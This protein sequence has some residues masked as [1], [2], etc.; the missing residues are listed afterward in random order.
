MFS[1]GKSV[2]S[3]SFPSILLLE[4]KRLFS[5]SILAQTEIEKN[6][7]RLFLLMHPDLMQDYS[8]TIIHKNDNSMKVCILVN[9]LI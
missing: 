5:K 3:F 8:K 2:L 7:K 6:V 9:S 1:F 4:G